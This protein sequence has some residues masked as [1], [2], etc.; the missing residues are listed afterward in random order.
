MQKKTIIG[1]LILIAAL[2]LSFIAFQPPALQNRPAMLKESSAKKREGQQT[3][4]GKPL[5]PIFPVYGFKFHNRNVT[6]G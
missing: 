5:P 1:T 2:A 4:L 6:F 3:H